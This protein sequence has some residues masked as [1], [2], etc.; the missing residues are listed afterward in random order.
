[1]V[2]KYHSV[3]GC[4][5]CCLPGRTPPVPLRIVRWLS[6]TI[7]ATCGTCPASG[8]TYRHNLYVWVTDEN[9]KVVCGSVLMAKAERS[10]SPSQVG[11]DGVSV[12][13]QDEDMFVLGR[14]TIHP[15][16]G[17]WGIPAGTGVSLKHK[18]VI[19]FLAPTS[20]RWQS[21]LPASFVRVGV[22]PSPP[23]PTRHQ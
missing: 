4:R 2:A 21:V 9:P 7:H 3:P 13:T 20:S 6:K 10:S 18:C 23:P 5:C 11:D 14:R 15:R 16:Q 22:P 8:Y 1:M 12:A 17:F 19:S